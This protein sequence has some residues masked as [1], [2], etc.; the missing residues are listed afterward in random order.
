MF[1][2]FVFPAA[3]KENPSNKEVTKKILEGALSHWFSDSRDL[4]P[5]CRKPK[6]KV[7]TAE[8]PVAII[9][10]AVIECATA[11]DTF[12]TINPSTLI[13]VTCVL[14]IYLMYLYLTIVSCLPNQA[15]SSLF[16]LKTFLS[17]LIYMQKNMK[18]KSR[19]S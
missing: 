17:A 4:G 19:I 18:L 5:E 10:E 7:A 1:I 8:P 13:M 2:I 6:I 15:V 12:L 3:A 9:T 11:A 16:S 14:V